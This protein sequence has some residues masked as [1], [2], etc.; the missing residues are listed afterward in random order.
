MMDTVTQRCGGL[1]YG[2]D[3]NPEQWPREVWDED[4]ALMQAAGVNL[5]SVGIFSWAWLEPKP[6]DYTFGWLDEVLDKLGAGGIQVGLATAT[7][8]P[9]AWLTLEHPEVLPV[10]ADGTRMS[11]G[12]RQA[13]CPSSPIFRERSLA[14]VER[15]ADRYGD[16]PTLTMWH[17]NNELGCHNAR[18]YCDVSAEA[19][20]AWLRDRYLDVD[21][22]NEAWG[23][24]FWSQRYAD[25][26]QILPPRA[27]P[28]IANPGHVLDFHR[29]SSDELLAQHRAERELLQRLT[30]GIPVT[31]NLMAARFNGGDYFSWAPHQD[32][33]SNDHYLIVDDPD[34]TVE[35]SFSADVTRGLAGGDPWLLMEHSTSAVNWQRRN[36]A[37]QPG[38]MLRNSLQHVAHGADGVMF[39]QWR[40][41]RAGAE[42]FHSAMVPHAGPDSDRHREVVVLGKALQRLAEV[43][44]SRV[45]ADVALVFDYEAWWALEFPIRPSVDVTYLDRARALHATLWGARVSVDVVPARGADLDR[46]K[47]VIVPTLFLASDETVDELDR[48]VRE[49]GTVLVTYL[50]GIVDERGHARLGGYP[51]AFRELLGVHVEEF[52]PLLAGQQVHLDDGTRAD[53]WTEK[54]ELRGAE[55]VASYVDGPLPGTPAITRNAHG[56]GTAWYVATRLDANGDA[57][58]LGRVVADLDVARPV[59][60]PR[61]VEL[62]RRRHDDGRSY[63]FALNHGDAAAMIEVRGTELLRDLTVGGALELPAGEVAVVREAG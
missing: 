48:Y 25:V 35:L 57:A 42:Q 30:P 3:Y 52:F 29:F 27:N 46:Y 54:L 56:E 40:Q 24:A 11:F 1:A 59:E 58:L 14:L 39:F 6:G 32:V 44:G 47:V 50:S 60:A 9:P 8:S 21:E 55:V 38:Q 36:L 61:G 17:V 28:A 18:C 43:A 19:F 23:T 45:E 13:W 34:A 53:V 31:T 2:G 16:H 7:A 22:L 10:T 26:D 49:G 12:G 51:G 4:V 15:L 5:V 20:R 41:S 63:V 37:K 62:V 33:V